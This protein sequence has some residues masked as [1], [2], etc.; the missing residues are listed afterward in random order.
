MAVADLTLTSWPGD[1]HQWPMLL[2]PER[3]NAG[4]A[5][6]ANNSRCRLVQSGTH[7]AFVGNAEGERQLS[8]LTAQVA[9][10]QVAVHAGQVLGPGLLLAHP[11]LHHHLRLHIRYLHI[12]H[13]ACHNLRLC[14]GWHEQCGSCYVAS[15]AESDP[16]S[17][18]APHAAAVATL[19][20]A[21]GTAFSTES[22]HED[23]SLFTLC[24]RPYS[25]SS[26]TEQ[27]QTTSRDAT[28]AVQP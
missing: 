10:L 11:A 3:S 24:R 13:K 28:N 16:I 7:G 14:C 18:L 8:L 2:S 19:T 23:S 4:C 1:Y 5:A 6:A 27:S 26:T 9:R 20:E 25:F 22:V 17:R 15:A 12:W 21:D